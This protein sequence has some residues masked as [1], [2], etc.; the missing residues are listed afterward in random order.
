MHHF[1]TDRH[2]E[3]HELYSFFSAG[4]IFKRRCFCCFV[5]HLGVQRANALR[6][7]RSLRTAL[8]K[9]QTDSSSSVDKSQTYPTITSDRRT[10]VPSVH[11]T[12]PKTAAFSKKESLINAKFVG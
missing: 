2:Y 3:F 10:V 11:V 5:S 9:F 4:V 8:Y 6:Y 1:L 7:S 12:P